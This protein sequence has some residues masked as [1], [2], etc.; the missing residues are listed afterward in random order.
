MI[1]FYKED[2]TTYIR[3]DTVTKQST[4]IDLEALTLRK[5]ELETTV[6]NFATTDEQLLAWAKANR[7]SE[8]EVTAKQ[9]VE[10]ELEAIDRTL[11]EI[12][13]L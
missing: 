9:K 13:G 2:A 4:T 5:A 6:A 12:A 3:F 8:A 10:S 11:G 7:W 1:K